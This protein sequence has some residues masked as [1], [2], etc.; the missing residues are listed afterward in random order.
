MKIYRNLVYIGAHNRKS[1]FDLYLS[2]SLKNLPLV[3]F[4]HGYKGFKDWGSWNKV[5]HTF[6]EAGFDFLKFNFSHNGG[7]VNNPIDFPDTKAFSENTYSKEV[8]DLAIVTSMAANGIDVNGESRSWDKIALIG[9]SRGGGIALI[10]ASKN[11]NNISHVVTWASVAD[12]GERFTQDID[13]WKKAGVI[14]VKNT[15]TNQELPHKFDFYQDYIENQD[16]LSIQRAA[17]QIKIPWLIIH[18]S[19]DESVNYENAIRLS[20]WNE[21]A[22]IHKVQNTGHTFGASHPALDENLPEPLNEVVIKTMEFLAV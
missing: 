13:D 11:K 19:E 3:I 16:R 1:L 8:E 6:A 14:T 12:Y 21:T 15:R 2:N 9:H 7:T 18:G 4:A 10:E 5:A 22:E 20:S 17:R